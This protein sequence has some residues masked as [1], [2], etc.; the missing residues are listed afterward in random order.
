MQLPPAPSRAPGLTGGAFSG[1][2]REGS[3]YLS[4][5]KSN[6]LVDVEGGEIRA[7]GTLF[8]V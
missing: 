5:L 6:G 7:S 3:L 8:E 1:R 2:H 4:K